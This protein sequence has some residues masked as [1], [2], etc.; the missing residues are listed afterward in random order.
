MAGRG[1]R[2]PNIV[3]GH[4]CV[5]RQRGVTLVELITVLVIIGVLGAI[6]ATRWFDRSSFDADA[7][8]EQSR[9]MLRYGQKVAIAQNREVY[10]RLNGDSVALCFA[11]TCSS[12]SRLIAPSG[13]NSGSKRTLSACTNSTSWYCEGKPEG[14]TYALVPASQYFGTLNFFYFDA[15]G[16]PFAGGDAPGTPTST[17][18]RLQMNI[19]GDGLTRTITVERETGYV[20]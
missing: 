1:F 16:K 17:F 13:A 5:C 15:Q 3:S 11:N 10:V 2:F 14:I 9:A 6:G 19:G 12:A 8:T 18:Q 20:H 4:S 7:F